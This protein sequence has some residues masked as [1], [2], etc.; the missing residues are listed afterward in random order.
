MNV[1]GTLN[2]ARQAAAA[3]VKRFVFISSVKVN[4]EG[5]S[6]GQPYTANDLPLPVDP[7]GISKYE[8][9]NGLL[10]LMKET[11]MEVVIIR[12]PLVYGPGVKAN[13]F[14]LLQLT[15]KSFPLPLASVLTVAVC[16]I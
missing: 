13:F 10:Q 14:K 7:Y 15:Q 5:T 3:G 16:F 4:G 2:L 6:L 11:G 1:H 12:L 8:A 9:E